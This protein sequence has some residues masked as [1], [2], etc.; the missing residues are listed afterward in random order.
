MKNKFGKIIVIT[1]VF[2]FIANFSFAKK[3]KFSVNMTGQVLDPTGVHVMGDFQEAAGICTN[4]TPDSAIMTKDLADT[5]IYYLY[6]DIPAFAKYEYLFINGA[7]SYLVEI[8]PPKAR[9]GYNNDDNRWIYIDSLAN[10][11]TILPTFKFSETSPAGLTMMRYVVDMTLQT[12]SPNGVHLAGDFQ[13]WNSST[14]RLYSFGSNT[15]E[16]ILYD[17]LGDAN[18]YNFYNGNTGANIE[19]VTGGCVINTMRYFT[20]TMDTILSKV[21]YSSCSTCYPLAVSDTK[22]ENEGKLYPNPMT[23]FTTIAFNDNSK[24]HQ[25]LVSDLSGRNILRFADIKDNSLQI[26]RNSL[27]SGI[28]IVSVLNEA[29]EKTTHK[30]SVE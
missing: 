28:Y 9:V 2:I 7:L 8:V 26:E 22:I 12:V 16:I 6:V 23:S 24:M 1:F 30:L 25:V 14:T 19:L 15:Y 3:V 20:L 5:N 18:N 21:C 17:T 11:T 27:N 4:W 29:G 13:G 10:D